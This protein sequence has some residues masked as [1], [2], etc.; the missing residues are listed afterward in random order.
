MK[1]PSHLNCDGKIVSEMGPWWLHY[2]PR[3]SSRLL[4]V[5]P[6]LQLLRQPSSSRLSHRR[7][8]RNQC[9]T[10]SYHDTGRPRSNIISHHPVNGDPPIPPVFSSNET[11]PVVG[12]AG[13]ARE[14]SSALHL[15]S[16]AISVVSC[17][18]SAVFVHPHPHNR[19]GSLSVKWML[20]QVLV[21]R[22]VGPANEGQRWQVKMLLQL[23]IVNSAGQNGERKTKML[24]FDTMSVTK[25]WVMTV[26]VVECDEGSTPQ[27]AD[28]SCTTTAS[29]QPDTISNVGECDIDSTSVPHDKNNADIPRTA[30]LKKELF[31]N[32]LRVTVG[33]TTVN[34]LI[35]IGASI[36]VISCNFISKLKPSL[37]K[38]LQS[39]I[40]KI[41]GVGNVAHDVTEKVQLSLTVGDQKLTQC[42]YILRQNQYDIILG[43]DFIRQHQVKM[44]FSFSDPEITIAGQ[45]HYL[46]PPPTRSMLAKT[47]SA[48]TIMGYS[49]M[50]VPVKLSKSLKTQLMLLE[51]V[52]S[53]THY[54]PGLSVA[55][56]L[57]SSQ[58]TYCRIANTTDTPISLP[59]NC[60]VAIARTTTLNC[61]T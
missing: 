33:N 51:P 59:N 46:Q 6:Q 21:G 13:H 61:I 38:Y 37:V 56:S 45:K 14:D 44:V 29:E 27:A 48:V 5:S 30:L 16:V 25:Q 24:I 42:F 60:V 10:P 4:L 34:G 2:R 53:L 36:S 1:F 47:L 22:I 20:F 8:G 58:V 54:A 7:C 19:T 49:A 32:T 17:P 55:D 9:R 18:T 41:Y 35:D 52:S 39:D 23:D 50:D 31:Q 12:V 15:V 40:S 11:A 26:L 57:V 3:L 43:M 28:S